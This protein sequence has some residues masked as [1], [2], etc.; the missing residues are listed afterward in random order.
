MLDPIRL[1]NHFKRLQK[2]DQYKKSS[3]VKLT[4]RSE[5]IPMKEEQ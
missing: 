1:A 4:H 3:R 5:W 2:A